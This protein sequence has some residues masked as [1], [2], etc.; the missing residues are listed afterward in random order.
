L[1]GREQAN[2]A[3]CTLKVLGATEAG[4]SNT[5]FGYVESLEFG[6]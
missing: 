6:I 3:S 4:D 2:V 5:V 1:Q